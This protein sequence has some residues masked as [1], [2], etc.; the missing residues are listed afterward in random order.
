M[1][2]QIDLEPTKP[3]YPRWHFGFDETLVGDPASTLAATADRL[4]PTAGSA[5]RSAWRTEH[6]ARRTAARETVRDHR[7]GDRLT[8]TVVSATLGDLVD[9]GAVVV[10]DATTSGGSVLE[11]VTRSTPGSYRATL[12]AGLG[13]GASAAVGVKLARPERRVVATVGDGSYVFANPTACAWLAAAHD[14]PTVTVVYNN[15]GWNAVRLSTLSQHPD[16]VAATEGLPESS[17]AP[18]LDLAKPAQVVDADTRTVASVDALR[19]AL[20]AAF[21]AADEGTPSVVDVHIEP[22]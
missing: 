6:E 16:G 9:D 4:D 17:F 5:G 7:A 21:T 20:E 3:A 14:A 1:T 12:G 13:W 15:A 10:N 8:P 22:V 11:H 18:R 19:P 2:V